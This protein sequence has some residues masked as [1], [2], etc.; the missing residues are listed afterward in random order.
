V[1]ESRKKRKAKSLNDA[2]DYYSS[3]K[4][5]DGPYRLKKSLGTVS[6]GREKR[7][8]GVGR[9]KEGARKRAAFRKEERR[10]CRFMG[11]Y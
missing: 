10:A 7:L 9:K 1:T 2:E 4:E 5:H 3:Q 6:R 11:K 8:R